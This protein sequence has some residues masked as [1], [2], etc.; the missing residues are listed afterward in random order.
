MFC[1]FAGPVLQ[2]LC[3]TLMPRPVADTD[4][5]RG[6]RGGGGSG[7]G[8]TVNAK[9]NWLNIDLNCQNIG[10]SHPK[11][12]RVVPHTSPHILSWR[13]HTNPSFTT[14]VFCFSDPYKHITKQAIISVVSAS[15]PP[16]KNDYYWWCPPLFFTKLLLVCHQGLCHALWILWIKISKTTF[17]TSTLTTLHMSV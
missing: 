9:L 12:T 8:F 5:C 13:D 2:L 3:E 11:F 14:N 16:P 17:A 6:G 7:G 4:G 15:Q 10:M 1:F